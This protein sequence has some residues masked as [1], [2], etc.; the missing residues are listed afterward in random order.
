[1]SHDSAEKSLQQREG[2]CI[3]WLDEIQPLPIPHLPLWLHLFQCSQLIVLAKITALAFRQVQRTF[4][5]LEMFSLCKLGSIL[6]K[7]NQIIVGALHLMPY[8]KSPSPVV[9]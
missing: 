3:Q 1:M 5:C 4:E 9:K 2:Y 8:F 7:H 6:I